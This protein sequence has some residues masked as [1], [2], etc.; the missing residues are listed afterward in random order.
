M[1]LRIQHAPLPVHLHQK[2]CTIIDLL[3]WIQ[4]L[5]ESGSGST[6]FLC[7][8]LRTEASM[9]LRIQHDPCPYTCTRRYVLVFT[10]CH[11]SRL[12]KSQV[13]GPYIFFVS[14][15]ELRLQCSSGSST[16]PCLYTC[17]RRYVLLL[18]YCHGSRH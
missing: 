3:P 10:Y 18:T 2:V 16:L 6:C 5:K 7:I 4:A 13:L 12:L 17:T 8:R 14:G 15:S 9:Q 1:Q 11:G